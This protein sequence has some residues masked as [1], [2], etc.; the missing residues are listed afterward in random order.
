MTPSNGG[1]ISEN[2]YVGSNGHL[3]DAENVYQS[4]GMRPSV[5][6]IPTV[7]ATYNTSEGADAPGTVNNPYVVQTN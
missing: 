3:S 2:W 7:Q 5:A 4:R 1:S 6:L